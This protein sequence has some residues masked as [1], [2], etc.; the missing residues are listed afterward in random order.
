MYCDC[1]RQCSWFNQIQFGW[2][3]FKKT[4]QSD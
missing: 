1:Y 2:K 4:Y 3:T